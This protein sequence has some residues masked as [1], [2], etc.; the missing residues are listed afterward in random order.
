MT[1]KTNNTD[2][3]PIIAA[4]G[5]LLLIFG[6]G[7]NLGN[8]TPDIIKPKTELARQIDA[9]APSGSSE[10]LQCMSESIRALANL[11]LIHI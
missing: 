8:I 9:T 3:T 6:G 4:I 10:D 5:G 2:W 11:S 7:L 1:T